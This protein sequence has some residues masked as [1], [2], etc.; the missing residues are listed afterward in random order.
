[1][2]AVTAG[3]RNVIFDLGEVIIDLDIPGTIKK[4]CKHSGKSPD[5]VRKIYTS[6]DVFLNY[7]KGLISDQDFRAGANELLGTSFE[8]DEFDLIWNGMLRDLPLKRLELLE[9]LKSKYRVFLLSNTNEIH[10]REF[11]G[12]VRSISGKASME[13]YF[14]K[15]YYSHQIKMRKPDA[16]I[17]MYVLQNSNLVPGETLFLDDN[18]DNIIGASACGIRAVRVINPDLIFE[19]FS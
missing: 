6:S 11:T 19:I 15:A 9:R 4:L 14:E 3:I 10:L 1:M 18:A 12:L 13:T 5:E 17:F 8:D 7:E 2:Q 16:E